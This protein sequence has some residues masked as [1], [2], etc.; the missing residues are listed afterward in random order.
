MTQTITL[1]VNKANVYDEIA[2]TTSYE[3]AKIQDGN[4]A[5][6]RIFTT[7][8][9]RMMLE[10]FWVEACNTITDEFK[11]YLA[12]VSEQSVSHGVD[13]SK[14]YTAELE[15]T[16]RYDSNLTDSIN[17]S[18]FSYFVAAIAGKWNRFVNKQGVENYINDAQAA[19]M[20]VKSK[21]Y[22]RKRPTRKVPTT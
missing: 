22:Y 8:D 4:N 20:D 15:L 5:Y 18:L 1:A 7:D 21:I 11:D 9:D 14:N 2:K 17:A 10:R 12:D 19:L 6:N 16:S 3:G 13:L